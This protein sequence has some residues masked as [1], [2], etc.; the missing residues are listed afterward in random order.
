MFYTKSN[1][2]VEGRKKT[3]RFQHLRERVGHFSQPNMLSSV[4]NIWDLQI[5][6]L[7]I[8]DSQ[9]L[10]LFLYGPYNFTRMLF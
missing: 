1:N 10:W 6:F 3:G 8:K 7:C 9:M 5:I 2:K 4:E